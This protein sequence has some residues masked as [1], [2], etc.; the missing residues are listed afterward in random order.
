MRLAERCRGAAIP[1]A[2]WDSSTAARRRLRNAQVC[3]G[4]LKRAERN[5][6]QSYSSAQPGMPAHAHAPRCDGLQRLRSLENTA[7]PTLERRHLLPAVVRPRL[8]VR[9][10]IRPT[11]RAAATRY[12]T[13]ATMTT[14][15][16]RNGRLHPEAP[17]LAG[18]A[19]RAYGPSRFPF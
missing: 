13:A 2:S 19:Q 5:P 6:A 8:R 14:A 4:G 7:P 16:S 1:S 9:K 11:S 18:S 3:A 15:S 10:K 12:T 17:D